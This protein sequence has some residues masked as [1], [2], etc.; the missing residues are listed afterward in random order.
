MIIDDICV[1]GGT[2]IG[3]AKMLRER[4]VG[5]LY[6]AISHLT[7]ESPNPILFSLFDKVF[8]TNSKGFDYTIEGSGHD[9]IGYKPENL[10]IIEM[11]D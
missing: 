10:E 1:N 8:T 6:L 11:F 3:L 5:K 2:F 4:N 7:V 9:K